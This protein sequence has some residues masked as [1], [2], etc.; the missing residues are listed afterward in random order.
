MP[1]QRNAGGMEAAV[2]YAASMREEGATHGLQATI[3]TKIRRIDRLR[4]VEDVGQADVMLVALFT[5]SA[6]ECG[7][8]MK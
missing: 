2:L 8:R 1:G 4:D 6:A 7:R 5:I 3:D